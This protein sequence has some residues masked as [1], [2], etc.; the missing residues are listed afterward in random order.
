M[1]QIQV[2]NTDK[3]CYPIEKFQLRFQKK[4]QVNSSDDRPPSKMVNLSKICRLCLVQFEDPNCLTD[5]EQAT[6]NLLNIMIQIDFNL[7][8]RLPY[9]ICFRCL[10]QIRD[11]NRFWK[12]AHDN[13]LK[14]LDMFLSHKIEIHE[15]CSSSF[16]GDEINVS[17]EVIID[18][19]M[20]VDSKLDMPMME[21]E[22]DESGF[23]NNSF[24]MTDD[25]LSDTFQDLSYFSPFSTPSSSP[26]VEIEDAEINYSQMNQPIAQPNVSHP[27]WF[28]SSDFAE[29]SQ[30][31]PELGKL[32]SNSSPKL[33]Q[34]G[35]SQC[36][37]CNVWVLNVKQHKLCV[38][39][40]EGQVKCKIC[41]STF[42]NSLKLS[43]H[44]RYKHN[45]SR[46]ICAFCAKPLKSKVSNHFKV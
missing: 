27:T 40:N 38:H 24:I 21:N 23:N 15:D 28:N 46:Y 18:N 43:M 9:K 33:D 25:G 41:S 42:S 26:S 39:V 37:E 12:Q 32:N 4:S 45:P 5:V 34:H 36:N 10:Q 2:K 31:I 20:E 35:R 17:H 22:S 30:Q 1:L 8:S 16:L 13:Q 6:A 29:S 44:I 14:I 7:P 11:Y 3:K 19:S